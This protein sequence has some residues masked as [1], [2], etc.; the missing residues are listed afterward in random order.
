[1][2]AAMAKGAAISA[3][4][5]RARQYMAIRNSI[6]PSM[7]IPPNYRPGSN[8]GLSRGGKVSGELKGM[9]TVLTSAAIVAT[10]NTNDNCIVLNLVQQG[11]G[12]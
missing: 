5:A 4:A 10:T 3:K 11:A 1:M 9:D 12:S 6:T 8:L 7:L 2:K